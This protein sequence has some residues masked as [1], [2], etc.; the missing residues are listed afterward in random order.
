MKKRKW[1]KKIVILCVV[2][3]AIELIAMLIMK[4][5][6]ERNIDHYDS[7]NDLI[8]VDDYYIG[9]GESDFDNSK[10][11]SKKYYEH[12]DTITKDKQR[13][14]A[15]QAKIV[16][17]DKNM[18]V[19]WENTIDNKFDA[20]FYSVIKVDDGFL[21]VGSFVDKYEQIDV[22]TRNAILVKYDLNGKLLWYKDYSVLSDT[23]F[24]KIIDDGNDNYVVIGQSIYENLEMGTHITGGG[25]IVRYDKEGNVLAYN[26]YGGNKSG[27]FNDI[28]KVDDGYIV[29]GKDA[30]NYGIVIKFK[31]DFGRD[32]NDKKIISNK[33]IWNRTYS[34]TD[35]KGFTGMSLVDNTIYAIGAVNVSKD[36]D[37]DDN[38]I[39]KYDAGIVLY[40]TNGKYLDKYSL[41]KDIHHRFNSFVVRD[42]EFILTGLYDVDNSND[43]EHQDSMI[44]KYNLFD[45]KFS[46]EEIKK[47]YAVS[48]I[49]NLNDKLLIIGNN[50]NNCGLLG[51]EYKSF[52]EEYK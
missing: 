40:N 25:I 5:M 29:C 8:M 23:E 14:L 48:K 35:E 52:M 12:T 51:C 18:N 7:L 32:E 1:L 33:I 42:K 17:Y 24:Y 16:K 19:L 45:N 15:N 41:G 46:T 10:F 28:I 4:I 47:D 31:K 3:I 37:K 2:I 36:K 34:N 11:V 13:I 43:S 49:V 6:N 38:P 44:V 50:H 22:N 20:T 39:Y 30:A 21:A 9:V 26:N 27:S